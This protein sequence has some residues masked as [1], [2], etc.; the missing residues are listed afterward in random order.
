MQLPYARVMVSACDIVVIRT[1]VPCLYLKNDV[2]HNL[3]FLRILSKWTHYRGHAK[4]NHIQI[5]SRDLYLSHLT[6]GVAS[7]SDY[8]GCIVLPYTRPTR[9]S[10]DFQAA[11]TP[12]EPSPIKLVVCSDI[13]RLAEPLTLC[14]SWSPYSSYCARPHSSFLGEV[15]YTYVHTTCMR[16]L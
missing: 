11:R 5:C 14:S 6:L 7:S 4:W 15:S 8:Y 16:S 12:P 10:V 1:W 3:I 9:A 13:W 2:A